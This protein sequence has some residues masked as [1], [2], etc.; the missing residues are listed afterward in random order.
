MEEAP[1]VREALRE[2]LREIDPDP[3]RARLER[4]LEGRPLTP[5]ILTVRT[6]SAIDGAVASEAAA[7][8]AAGVQLIYEGLRLTRRLVETEPWPPAGE[9]DP[10]VDVVAA[11][12]LV[13]SGLNQLAHTGVRDRVV[14]I[15]RRFGRTHSRDADG[16]PHEG[17]ASDLDAGD[18]PLDVDDEPSLEADVVVLAIAAGADLAAQTVPPGLIEYARE[19]AAEID[20]DPLPDGEPIDDVAETVERIV[21]AA[22]SPAEDRSRSSTLDP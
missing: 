12:V 4:T 7:Q 8:R 13:A 10:D 20:A 9:G 1:R 21:A 5:G 16:Q 3:F 22:E 14:E 18:S 17:D 11:E 6:A 2:S 19:L 15:I